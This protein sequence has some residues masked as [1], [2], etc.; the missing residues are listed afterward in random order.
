MSAQSTDITGASLPE[1]EAGGGVEGESASRPPSPPVPVPAARVTEPPRAKPASAPEPPPA[2]EPTPQAPPSAEGG[3]SELRMAGLS[4]LLLSAFLIGFAAYL[5]GF[6]SIQESRDQAT[7][8][9]QLRYELAQ[10]IA[11]TGPTTPGV[12]VAILNSPSIGVR[13]LVVVEGT[14]P[15]N[16]MEGPGLVRNTPLPGQG[17]VSEIYGRL[18]SFGGPF[19]ALSRLRVGDEIKVTTSLG[20]STYKVAAFGDS[21]ELVSDPAPNRLILL[22]AGSPYV[23]TYYSYVDADLIS[24]VQPQPGGLPPIYSDETAMSGDTGALVIALLW[25]LALVGVSAACTIA[26]ARWTPWPAYLA[27]APIVIVVVWNLY[28]SLAAVL[29]NVY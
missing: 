9:A 13:N 23:P 10:A 17:G 25:A 27:A 1:A 24:S 6:S 4:L 18:A 26:A 11:P 2:P 12:P 3:R 22:T 19:S 16:L 15:E 14:T 8:Y 20:I 21:S 7:L 5:F 28:R 29:P